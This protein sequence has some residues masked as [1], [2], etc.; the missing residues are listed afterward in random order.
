MK[1]SFNA[2]GRTRDEFGNLTI[3]IW[4]GNHVEA[5]PV[6]GTLDRN[7]LKAGAL[8]QAGCPINIA[9]KVITPFLA[10]E[11]TATEEGVLTV[12]VGNYG[13]E[14]TTKDYLQKVGD[15][16]SSL[17]GA[18]AITAVE[19]TDKPHV[20][21]ITVAIDGASEHDV[22]VLS[23]VAGGAVAP[24]AYLYNDIYIGK[25]FDVTA[26]ETA[27]TGAAIMYNHSGILIDR[28]PAGLVKEQMAKAVPGVYQHNE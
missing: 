2:Y 27:A 3:P 1:S 6:G 14:P 23:P 25:E 8:Y 11:V 17:E 9:N 7:Y 10:M 24:N 4:L 16:F 20:Y 26:E 28:T 5:V 19:E 12:D 22:V 18:V 13:I 21:K 15:D